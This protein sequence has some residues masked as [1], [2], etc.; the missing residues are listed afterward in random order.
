[1]TIVDMLSIG[2]ALFCVIL[3]VLFI[4]LSDEVDELRDVAFVAHQL[5]LAVFGPE[6]LAE[7]FSE[8]ANGD[9]LERVEYVGSPLNSLPIF[10]DELS[11]RKITDVRTKERSIQTFY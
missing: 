5:T 10:A 3:I 11:K 9:I 8:A 7:L 1:M 4:R 2:L 6:R